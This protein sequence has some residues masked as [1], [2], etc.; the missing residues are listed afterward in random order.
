MSFRAFFLGVSNCGMLSEA[1]STFGC[2]RKSQDP[3]PH[4]PRPTYLSPERAAR[5][6]VDGP[7]QASSLALCTDA[8]LANLRTA[9]AALDMH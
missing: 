7:A 6:A 5:A 8:L 2:W 9:F 4:L 3:Y 1:A